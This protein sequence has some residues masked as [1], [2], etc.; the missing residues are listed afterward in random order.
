MKI[1][2]KIVG[3]SALV[4]ILSLFTYSVFANTFNAPSANNENYILVELEKNYEL[5]A[6]NK[7]KYNKLSADADKAECLAGRA[8]AAWKL[9]NASV[10][11][12]LMPALEEKARKSCF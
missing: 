6:V 10:T 8:L 7:Q 12:K 1:V 11:P 4:V 5:T 3:W 2:S 9:T